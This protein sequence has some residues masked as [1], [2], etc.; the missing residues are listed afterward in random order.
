MFL[1]EF[2]ITISLSRSLTLAYFRWIPRPEVLARPGIPNQPD[3]AGGGPGHGP[4]PRP[5]RVQVRHPRPDLQ[6]RILPL[7]Q[8]LWGRGDGRI[9]IL[10]SRLLF[11]HPFSLFELRALVLLFT[12]SVT[13]VFFY[14]GMKLSNIVFTLNV[15]FIYQRFIADFLAI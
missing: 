1:N 13:R 6:H 5:V 4:R 7:A 14:L 3:G 15:V 8:E 10:Y 9:T 2:L 11:S 12:H